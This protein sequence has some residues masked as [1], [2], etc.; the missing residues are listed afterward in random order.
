MFVYTHVHACLIITI[1]DLMCII[2]QLYIYIIRIYP[3]GCMDA[4]VKKYMAFRVKQLRSYNLLYIY[5]PTYIFFALIPYTDLY[6]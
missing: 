2:K 4:A 5:V 1:Y 3:P 6:K